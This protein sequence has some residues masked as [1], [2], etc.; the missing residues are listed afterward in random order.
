MPQRPTVDRARIVELIGQGVPPRAVATRLGASVGT[1]YR[2][3]HELGCPPKPRKA[4]HA[5]PVS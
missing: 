4:R 3:M 1:V 2:T 5:H